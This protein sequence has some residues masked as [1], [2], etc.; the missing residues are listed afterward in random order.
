MNNAEYESELKRIDE[1]TK[2]LKNEAGRSRAQQMLKDF[3]IKKGDK[4]KNK[5]RSIEVKRIGWGCGIYQGFGLI[6]EGVLLTKKGEP[7]KNGDTNS[8]C[9]K[10]KSDFDF[11]D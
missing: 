6:V 1:L 11:I 3:N 7:K 9:I 4:I 8:I 10:T 2:T 5:Y